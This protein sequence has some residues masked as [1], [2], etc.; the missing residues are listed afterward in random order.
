MKKKKRMSMKKRKK[1]KREMMT[2]TVIIKLISL[3]ILAKYS[4]SKMFRSTHK[5]DYFW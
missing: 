5:I 2:K 4:Y 3:F 1:M